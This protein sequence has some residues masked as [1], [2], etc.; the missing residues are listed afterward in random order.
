MCVDSETGL[1]LQIVSGRDWTRRRGSGGCAAGHLLNLFFSSCADATFRSDPRNKRRNWSRRRE[2]GAAS[3]K[4]IHAS[5]SWCAWW[6]CAVVAILAA[7]ATR[8]C[9]A[10]PSASG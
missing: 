4:G 3:T 1:H 10:L 7:T 9:L 5:C 6:V 2:R 8:C